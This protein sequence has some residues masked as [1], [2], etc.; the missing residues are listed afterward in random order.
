MS[1]SKASTSLSKALKEL[2]AIKV[3]ASNVVKTPDL[4]KAATAELIKTLRAGSKM[5]KVHTQHF[6][7]DRMETPLPISAELNYYNPLRHEPTHGHL[8]AEVVFKCYDPRN[9]ELFADFALRAA[10]YLGMPV[11]GAT[12]INKKI[13]RWTVIRAPFTM[14]KSKEGFERYTHGRII[15][16]FDTTDEVVD[17]WLAYI[18]ENSVWGVGVKVNKFE[19]GSVDEETAAA[20]ATTTTTTT[21]TTSSSTILQEIDAQEGQVAQKVKELL[22]NPVF[23]RH[24]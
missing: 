7:P 1:T 10:Y 14:A 12:P 22:A 20:E 19:A 3:A 21:T 13:E 8:K 23:A 18:K 24:M 4:H 11:S 6:I 17:L 9:V 5:N 15:K 16:V 2:A